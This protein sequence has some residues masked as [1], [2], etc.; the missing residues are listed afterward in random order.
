MDIFVWQIMVLLIGRV[1]VSLSSQSVLLQAICWLTRALVSVCQ[2]A[3]SA[4][5]K[6][7]VSESAAVAIQ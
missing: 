4:L 3:V 7:Q 5:D 6:D 2:S 1:M